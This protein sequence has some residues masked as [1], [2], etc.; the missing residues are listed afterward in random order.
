MAN[1]APAQDS[2][3]DVQVAFDRWRYSRSEWDEFEREL[4]ETISKA[5]GLGLKWDD[6]E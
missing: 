6:D 3:D 1:A 4:A 2:L 5:L